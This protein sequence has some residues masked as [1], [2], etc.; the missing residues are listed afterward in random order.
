MKCLCYLGILK[1]GFSSYSSQVTL[2]SQKVTQD[3]KVVT[4]CRH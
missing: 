1:E 2:I 4:D 3:K